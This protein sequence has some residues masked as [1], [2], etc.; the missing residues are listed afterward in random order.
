MWFE[1]VLAL[2]PVLTIGFAYALFRSEPVSVTVW[3]ALIAASSIAFLVGGAVA[4][5]RLKASMGHTICFIAIAVLNAC[6]VLVVFALPSVGA[7][8]GVGFGTAAVFAASAFAFR[9]FDANSFP[10]TFAVLA[11]AVA[12]WYA[13][14]LFQSIPQFQKA[15][16]RT[17]FT[18]LMG[19]LDHVDTPHWYKT[20]G[21]L[22]HSIG[23]VCAGLV[24]FELAR[25]DQKIRAAMEDAANEPLIAPKAHYGSTGT[26]RSRHPAS[27]Y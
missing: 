14:G 27:T 17:P 7:I 21:C 22:S 6:P 23:A 19:N 5:W 25:Y 10:W 1:H 4:V 26:P 12:G 2:L 24:L 13:F 18:G 8:G 16:G 9:I 3:L 11:S 15:W 20:A